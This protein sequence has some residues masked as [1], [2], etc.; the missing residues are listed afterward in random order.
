L[1]ARTRDDIRAPTAATA[2]R[3]ATG[4]TGW[5]WPTTPMP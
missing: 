1:T 2:E 3:A 4:S 5:S